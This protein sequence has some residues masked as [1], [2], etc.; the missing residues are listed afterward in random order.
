MNNQLKKRLEKRNSIIKWLIYYFIISLSYVYMTTIHF[1]IP[2][3]IFLVPIA[4]CISMN[5]EP[6]NAAI[7]GCICGLMTDSAMGTL[8]G[9]HAI[10][11]MW[12]CTITSLLFMFIMRQHILNV[13]FITFI[14]T[15]IQAFLN[16]LFYYA[17]WGYDKNGM[18]LLDYFLPTLI[19]TNISTIAF[20]Y[21]IKITAT[22]FGIIKEHFIEE[23]SDAIVRE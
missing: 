11:L 7:T 9:F 12:C 21:L 15:L 19:F 3:P 13:I 6:L 14:V 18:I 5:E 1:N 4:I 8:V 22:K 16:Y 23:K 2:N 10:I 20:Y 17:I